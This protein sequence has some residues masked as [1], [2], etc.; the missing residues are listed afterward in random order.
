MTVPHRS[1]SAPPQES[2]DDVVLS[3]IAPCFNEE[4][5]IDVLCDRT[6]AVFDLLGIEAEF[7]LIDDGSRDDTW[8]R[9]AHRA[10]ID[11]RIRAAR[12]EVNRGIEAAWC[13]GHR[14][15]RGHLVCL[16]DADLQNRPE[17]IALLYR[18]YLR[19]LPDL[20]QGVRRPVRGVTRCKLFSR[21]LNFLLNTLFGMKLRDNKSGF[22]LCRRDVLRRL[23]AHR[24]RY[25]YFQSLIG[26]AAGAAGFTIGEVE[27]RF[28]PRNAGTSF[29]HRFPV[30]VS[31]RILKEMLRFRREI[32]EAT[33]PES[34]ENAGRT[35]APL[36]PA[37]GT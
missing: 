24:G 12:H 14:E 37:T 8:R 20:V 28:E 6:L 31:C 17:D 27:T 21:G 10:A 7:I 30:L 32:R 11:S 25:A 16:I 19:T 9:I 36:A 22:L 3:V 15:C 33:T 34:S 13:T 26:V 18:T 1:N 29:L 23:L 5:N 35:A 4:G 2:H